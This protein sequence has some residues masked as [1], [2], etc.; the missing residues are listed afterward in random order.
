M[1]EHFRIY[2][3]PS[4]LADTTE[5]PDARFYIAELEERARRDRQIDGA[6]V[7]WMDGP[8]YVYLGI[9][10]PGHDGQTW[11]GVAG[12][13]RDMEYLAVDW[14]ESLEDDID[15][16]NLLREWGGEDLMNEF[17]QFVAWDD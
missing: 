8:D 16:E 15:I 11:I 12:I 9:A 4:E 6:S 7:Y 3:S 13:P 10:R 5:A 14:F 17:E 2:G 1:P